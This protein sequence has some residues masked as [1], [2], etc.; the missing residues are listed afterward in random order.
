MACDSVVLTVVGSHQNS[1]DFAE[2]PL[3][4]LSDGGTSQPADELQPSA[5]AG[6][7]G[8]TSAWR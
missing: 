6:T 5:H 4:A 2:R 1:L 8:L 7:C 3:F